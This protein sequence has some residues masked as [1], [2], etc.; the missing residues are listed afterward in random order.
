M[1]VEV[2]SLIFDIGHWFPKPS[3]CKQSATN[4]YSKCAEHKE[5]IKAR[6]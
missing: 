5:A 4:V 1:E 3:V 2:V 6:A